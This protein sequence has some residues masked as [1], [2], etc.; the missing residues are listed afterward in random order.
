MTETN[1]ADEPGVGFTIAD[2]VATIVL[3]NPKSGNALTRRIFLALRDAWERIQ[4]DPHIRVAVF[5]AAGEKH[6]CT[7]ADVAALASQG[8]LRLPSEA[9]G[10]AWRLTWRMA[11]VTKP[12]VVAVNGTA[13]GG[14]LGFVTDGDI[15]MAAKNARFMDTHVA[16]GQICGYG[17][18]RLAAIIGASEAKRI[19]LAGGVLTAERAYQLGLVNELFETPAEALAAA[20]AAARKIAAASPAALRKTFELFSGL[21]RTPQEQEVVRKADGFVD[22]HMTHPDATEGANAWLQKRK[23]VWAD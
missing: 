7:G 18:L 1:L 8:S 20:Q 5:T 17:A 13:A 4:N 14:G 23:P 16:M 10:E 3:N 22:G 21:S 15:V 6:F 2:G 19:A 11:C 9:T 12:V